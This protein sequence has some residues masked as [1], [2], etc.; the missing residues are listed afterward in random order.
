MSEKAWYRD[1]RFLIPSLLV[2]VGLAVLPFLL[3]SG[4]TRPEQL[5]VSAGLDDPR[6]DDPGPWDQRSELSVEVQDLSSSEL[7][8]RVVGEFLAGIE[9][10]PVP[11]REDR[12]PL[13]V[14][15][16][17]AEDGILLL[18][19]ADSELVALHLSRFSQVRTLD[20]LRQGADP[21]V[22]MMLPDDGLPP[23]AAGPSTDES[24]IRAGVYRIVL[25]APSYREYSRY[26]ELTPQG[27]LLSEQDFEIQPMELPLSVQ[28][29]PIVSRPP[30]VAVPL[31]SL[32]PSSFDVIP[33]ADLGILLQ[34]AMVRELR[35]A[36]YRAI[37]LAEG[38]RA[39]FDLNPSKGQ[40]ATPGVVYADYA[41]EWRC[42][43]AG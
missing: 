25:T 27:E 13:S 15:L 35:S 34:G 36:G 31:C 38:E 24:A 7:A 22:Q 5:R 40:P 8:S 37:A 14:S 33:T 11:E 21:T 28:L 41:I 9:L 16:N 17:L 26:L 19:G 32:A 2:P 18:D 29:Q 20:E 23:V 42:E 3:E 1:P 12:S 43:W 30:T 39:G 4:P 6:R 10:P